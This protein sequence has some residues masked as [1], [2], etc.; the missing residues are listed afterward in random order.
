MTTKDNKMMGHNNPPKELEDLIC[1]Q[2]FTQKSTQ[3]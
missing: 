1:N 3:T 2:S